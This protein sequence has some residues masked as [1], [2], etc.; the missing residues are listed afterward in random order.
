MTPATF[1]DAA[2]TSL[3]IDVTLLDDPA[4]GERPIHN[5]GSATWTAQERP[6]R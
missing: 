6:R 3:R 1:P 2:V 4:T 5:P